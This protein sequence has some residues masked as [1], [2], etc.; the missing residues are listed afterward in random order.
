VTLPRADYTRVVV[1]WIA[2]LIALF[3]FQEYFG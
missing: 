3:A 2:V 1:V